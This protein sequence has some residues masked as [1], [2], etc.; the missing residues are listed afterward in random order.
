MG[1]LDQRL[2]L[3]WVPSNVEA[4]GGDA[5]RIALL[6]ESSGAASGVITTSHFRKI[7]VSGIITDLG[8]CSPTHKDDGFI[9]PAHSNFTFVA[10]QLGCCSPTAHQDLKFM[11]NISA[12]ATIDTLR[13]QVSD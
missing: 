3:E 2:G 4:F 10:E 7:H 1:F 5:S 12:E 11:C 6:G 8:T 9:D 13:A